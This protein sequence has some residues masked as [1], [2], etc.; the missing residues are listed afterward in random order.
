MMV[1]ATS[2]YNQGTLFSFYKFYWVKTDHF[3]LHTVGGPFHSCSHYH[4][5]MSLLS[6]VK[7]ALQSELNQEVRRLERCFRRTCS[8]EDCVA[9]SEHIQQMHGIF[10][11]GYVLGESD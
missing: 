8:A 2:D 4:N 3:S 7:P 11:E 5:S 9:W 10:G 6:Q 1:I